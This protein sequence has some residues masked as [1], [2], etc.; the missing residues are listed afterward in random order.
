VKITPVPPHRSQRSSHANE[1]EATV[2]VPFP[3]T[4]GSLGLDVDGLIFGCDYNPEQWDSA[5]WADDVRLMKQAGINLV[6]INIFGWSQVEP[7]AGHFQ[8]DDLD[9]IIALLTNAGIGVNLG[10]GTSTP[11]PWVTTAHPEILPTMA[12]GTRRWP[13][14]RQAWCP[15]SPVFR[16][17]ALDLVAATAARYGTHPGVKLWHVSNEL[18]CHNAH[19]Y[20]DVSAAAFRFWLVAKYQDIESLNRAWG[21]TFWSQHYAQ[22]DEVLPPRKTLSIANSA[23][24]LDF[25]RFSSDELLSYYLAEAATI[26]EHSTKPVTTNFMVTAH[27]KT[28]DYWGWADSMDVIANDHY[29]DHRL[30]VPERELSFAADVTRGLAGGSPWLLMES[31]TSAVNWQ[32]VNHAKAPGQLKRNSLT[33]LARGA[34]GICFFQWRA[35][36]QGAEKFHSALL[37]HAGTGSRIWKEVVELGTMMGKLAEIAGT[38]VTSDIA[39]V[40][41]WESWWAADLEAHPSSDLRYLEQVHALYGALLE[42][43]ATV[44]IV[45]PD[46]ALDDY[47]LVVVPSLY[48]VSDHTAATINRFVENGGHAVITFFSG[49]VDETDSIRLGGYPGAFRQMLG[50]SVDEFYPLAPGES[51]PL[52]DGSR[53][54]LWS[55]NL[56]LTTAESLVHYTSGPLQE[57]PAVT[58]NGFGRG[59]GWYLATALQPDRL[60]GILRRVATEA[61]VQE[62]ADTNSGVEIVRRRGVDRDYVFVLNHTSEPVEHCFAGQELL[63][64]TTVADIATIEA[65]GV[66]VIRQERERS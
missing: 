35:S 39:L 53:S 52:S 18:G 14:G 25:D 22:W 9:E 65:G 7:R 40:F 28:Q 45:P 2:T 41:S 50:V 48:L 26:R 24:E 10:T 32:P 66:H 8:F 37:P 59:V 27:I 21:T 51:L 29:L 19:C 46:A 61:A 36:A 58:R 33:H 5:I 1:A 49:I 34:D 63:T 23:Q 60:A 38:T 31:A 17:L 16:S 4:A 55:E 57:I 62:L 20:C 42:I 47:R 6:A 3:P 43:G 13:G 30:A 44:D 54:T 56:G 64:G 12:D 15:S 11:P